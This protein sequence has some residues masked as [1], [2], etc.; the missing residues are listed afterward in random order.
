[1]NWRKRLGRWL[2]LYNDPI[3][4]VE[5]IEDDPS[6]AYAWF[7]DEDASD[8]EVAEFL[9]RLN[10]TYGEAYGREPRATHFV[11]RQPEELRQLDETDI[12]QYVRPWLR[13]DIDPGGT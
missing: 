8:E 7:L 13:D 1:M 10:R 6:I 2:G 3:D 9:D 12:K 5:A 4:V 11:V